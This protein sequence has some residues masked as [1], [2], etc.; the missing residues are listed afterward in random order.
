MYQFV[1]PYGGGLETG[2]NEGMEQKLSLHGN[3]MEKVEAGVGLT[4]G[5]CPD[6]EIKNIYIDCKPPTFVSSLDVRQGFVK[7]LN[8]FSFQK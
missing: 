8:E 4:S 1:E 7:I 6:N 2:K 5:L 3:Q